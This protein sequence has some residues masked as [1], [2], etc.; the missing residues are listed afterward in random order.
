MRVYMKHEILNL[1]ETI[2]EAHKILKK[3]ADKKRD[4]D[5]CQCLIQL[6]EAAI[7]TG[8]RIEQSGDDNTGVIHN[9]EAYCEEVYQYGEAKNV[10]HKKEILAKMEREIQIIKNKII[11]EVRED[12]LEIVFMPYKADMWTS[13][14]SIWEAAKQDNE[15]K[16]KVVPLPYYD[17]ADIN[18]VKFQYEAER[19]PENVEITD[20]REYSPEQSHPDMI[21]I[22]NPYD[23]CNNLTRVPQCYYSSN[24]KNNSEMLIYSPYFTVGTFKAEKQAFMFTMPGVYHSDFVIAQSGKV[25]KLFEEFG[26]Q[27]NKILAFGSPKIDAVIKN[28]QRKRIMP[29]AWKDKIEGKKVFLLNTHLS[30]FPKALNYAKS[31]DNYAVKFHKEILQ[32]FI[33]RD[34]CALIWRPHPLLKNMLA[35][36]FRE[37]LE[38]VNY[39]EKRVKRADN[40]IV[41]ETGDYFDAFYCSDALISTWSSLINEYMVTGKPVLIFQKKTDA[42][43]MQNSPLDRNINYFR[44]GKDKLTFEKFR[45]NVINQKDPLFEK[46]NQAVKDAFPNLDGLAGEKIFHYLKYIYK[47]R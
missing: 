36:R 12:K 46:R 11:Y 26:H 42:K 27:S 37:C 38:F 2:K 39:F 29:Q 34:D 16:V 6:Q 14:A 9:L 13:L 3:L 32:T 17:I 15:C 43:I 7:M 33:D 40:G 23:E 18:N 10:Q 4:A 21:F 30:Y 5:I 31:A 20:Y 8:N 44:L 25:K 45:D 1:I 24:L 35:G 22:H 47:Q 28:E 41:D 19:F